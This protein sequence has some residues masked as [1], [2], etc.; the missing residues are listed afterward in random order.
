M[1]N[2]NALKAIYD[3][4]SKFP[5]GPVIKDIDLN[6]LNTLI[7]G[8]SGPSVWALYDI[9]S[10]PAQGNTADNPQLN[11]YYPARF[12]TPIVNEFTGESEVRVLTHPYGGWATGGNNPN[13]VA[14]VEFFLNGGPAVLGTKTTDPKTN[15]QNIWSAKLPQGL[16]ADIAEIRAKVYPTI[17]KVNVLQGTGYKSS[18]EAIALYG[19]RR[20]DDSPHTLVPYAEGIY[21]NR[22]GCIVQKGLTTYYVGP[23]GSDSNDGLSLSTAKLTPQAVCT[24]AGGSNKV[25]ILNY[26]ERTNALHASVFVK[27]VG[28]SA[29]YTHT[30]HLPIVEGGTIIW[31]SPSTP[32]GQN[33]IGVIFNNV[34]FRPDTGTGSNSL[35]LNSVGAARYVFIDCDMGPEGKLDSHGGQFGEIEEQASVGTIAGL[36]MEVVQTTNR[37]PTFFY[38][39]D[40]RY[41]TTSS[42]R[43]AIDSVFVLPPVQ[44]DVCNAQLIYNVKMMDVGPLTYPYGSAGKGKFT[45]CPKGSAKTYVALGSTAGVTHTGI[46][47][48]NLFDTFYYTLGTSAGVSGNPYEGVTLTGAFRTGF[49]EWKVIEPGSTMIAAYEAIPNLG[50]YPD[51]IFS[52]ARVNEPWRRTS[53]DVS[54]FTGSTSESNPTQYPGGT[55]QRG[56]SG[57]KWAMDPHLDITQTF[58]ESDWNGVATD[59]NVYNTLVCDLYVTGHLNEY[60][61]LFFSDNSRADGSAFWNTNLQKPAYVSSSQF[62]LT[63]GRDPSIGV[64]ADSINQLS[65]YVHLGP[66][67]Q[68]NI[69]EFKGRFGAGVAGPKEPFPQYN[70]F[71]YETDGWKFPTATGAEM[72]D[73]ISGWDASPSTYSTSVGA[74]GSVSSYQIS[75]NPQINSRYY[76]N[77]LNQ[78]GGTLHDGTYVSPGLSADSRAIGWFGANFRNGAT[79]TWGGQ[80]TM[81]GTQARFGITGQ[82]NGGVI[83]DPTTGVTFQVWNGTGWPGS[84]EMKATTRWASD[85]GWR[86]GVGITFNT[87]HPTKEKYWDTILAPYANPGITFPSPLN[88]QDGYAALSSVN[89]L[90][91]NSTSVF[92]PANYVDTTYGISATT[93]TYDMVPMQVSFYLE[94]IIP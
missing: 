39:C 88:I 38:N 43:E 40:F 5:T 86:L 64:S 6:L 48:R 32:G 12:I 42:S 90:G 74:S 91:P 71:F 20:Q 81:S 23:S 55:S 27:N 28:S 85:N 63:G 82:N 72:V 76:I 41:C 68:N 93:F 35:Q 29:D 78:V 77:F 57:T 17:G 37:T 4:N 69:G 16:S 75:D 25:K 49:A 54:Y 14:K 31:N 80:W 9:D 53:I 66:Y 58:W 59:G 83:T 60:Q 65:Q 3:P 8:T 50:F 18:Q 10:E 89:F 46:D 44:N 1:N 26:Y 30:D 24:A 36:K 19:D 73:N 21:P 84:T 70:L 33:N 79:A 45:F 15:Q 11:Y 62:T 2:I 13:G 34:D 61:G 22:R 56:W 94:K 52:L 51:W 47:V 87:G 7:E 92:V 67:L